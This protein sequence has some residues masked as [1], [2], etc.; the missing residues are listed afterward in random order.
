MAAEHERVLKRNHVPSTD[1]LSKLVGLWPL[2]K[3][4]PMHL[5]GALGVV[6]TLV[7]WIEK[8]S[9]KDPSR[10]WSWLNQQIAWLLTAISEN[11]VMLQSMNLAQSSGDTAELTPAKLAQFLQILRPIGGVQGFLQAFKGLDIATAATQA[12]CLYDVNVRDL[13]TTRLLTSIYQLL[14]ANLMHLKGLEHFV[15]HF[16][17]TFVAKA[18]DM[19]GDME[20]W[21]HLTNGL[22]TVARNPGH[23]SPDG[24]ELPATSSG[25]QR[26]LDILSL[27]WGLEEAGG[28]NAEPTDW[29]ALRSYLAINGLHGVLAQMRNE[30]RPAAATWTLPKPREPVKQS[31]GSCGSLL[32]A[33]YRIARTR[34]RPVSASKTSST[35]DLLAYAHAGNV[36]GL[37]HKLADKSVAHTFAEKS[38]HCSVFRPISATS[39]SRPKSGKLNCSGYMAGSPVRLAPVK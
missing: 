16:G 32:T 1:V 23:V 19:L 39:G 20:R 26:V 8:Y 25:T 22:V 4:D 9:D 38:K 30:V 28:P 5:D 14:G 10:M 35:P 24:L 6:Y 29:D 33:N 7:R 12:R 13:N 18:Q 2:L 36:S 37:A 3:Q 17:K 21:E 15:K 31:C 27:G 11:N 34:A